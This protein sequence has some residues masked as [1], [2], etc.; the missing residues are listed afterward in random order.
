[1]RDPFDLWTPVFEI[2]S[3]DQIWSAC[4]HITGDT[5]DMFL[6]FGRQ[7]VGQLP[8]E[9]LEKMQKVLSF[10]LVVWKAASPLY[11]TPC[12]WSYLC[13]I[14]C[15]AKLIRSYYVRIELLI[16]RYRCIPCLV[17]LYIKQLFE[18]LQRTMSQTSNFAQNGLHF[19]GFLNRASDPYLVILVRESTPRR[20]I[21]CT[22]SDMDQV[23][24]YHC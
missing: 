24:P 13:F 14:I 23:R 19:F 18:G 6:R 10:L 7:A 5:L 9:M 15:S 12:H 21:A 22:R 4:T 11:L 3:S 1:M 2:R 16:P 17:C 20:N 8:P